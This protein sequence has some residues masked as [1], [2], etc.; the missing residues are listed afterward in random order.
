MP[1]S[2]TRRAAPQAPKL[3]G[4][5][6]LFTM[7]NYVSW[8]DALLAPAL[9]DEEESMGSASVAACVPSSAR[10]HASFCLAVS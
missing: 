10:H 9:M 4:I 1:C 3:F 2:Y 6:L 7:L 8:A 5:N